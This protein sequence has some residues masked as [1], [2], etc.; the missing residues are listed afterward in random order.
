MID[1]QFMDGGITGQVSLG[2]T[3]VGA[4]EVAQTGPATFVRID[5]DFTNAVSILIPRPFI[6]SMAD[7]MA[8]TL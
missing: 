2:N 4:Q 5:M 1:C 6:L 3:T 7:C 8:H